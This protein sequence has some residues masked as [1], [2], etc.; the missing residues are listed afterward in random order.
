M[1]A[2]VDPGRLSVVSSGS[3][4]PIEDDAKVDGRAKRRRV[5]LPV[6][7]KKDP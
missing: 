6:M 4:P 7:E 5:P 1:T 2:R 3:A